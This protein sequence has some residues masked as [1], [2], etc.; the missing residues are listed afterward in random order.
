[1]EFCTYF[2]KNFKYILS[3]PTIVFLTLLSFYLY[4]PEIVNKITND[5]DYRKLIIIFGLM[6]SIFSLIML[7]LNIFLNYLDN[8][9]SNIDHLYYFDHKIEKLLN[10]KIHSNS[11]I[12]ENEKKQLIDRLTTQFENNISDEFKQ[13]IEERI[14]IK[15]LQKYSDRS[16]FRLQE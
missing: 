7:L 13:K 3:G 10:N 9:S 14:K 15:N 8:K 6:F 2:N 1:M 4:N 12:T 11:N 16:I 5:I